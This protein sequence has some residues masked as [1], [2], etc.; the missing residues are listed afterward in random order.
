MLNLDSAVHFFSDPST[1]TQQQQQQHNAETQ[2]QR[3][4]HQKWTLVNCHLFED[5]ID[6][7]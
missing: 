6:N 7:I 5:F 4:L 2:A 3:L 1:A